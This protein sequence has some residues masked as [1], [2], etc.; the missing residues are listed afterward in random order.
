M[1]YILLL[2]HLR[3]SGSSVVPTR[4][5]LHSHTAHNHFH[6]CFSNFHVLDMESSYI[7]SGGAIVQL[8]GRPSANVRNSQPHEPSASYNVVVPLSD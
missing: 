5:L 6:R 4:S 3:C 1:I 7:P 2:L 8:R